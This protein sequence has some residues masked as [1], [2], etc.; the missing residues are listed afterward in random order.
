MNNQCNQLK[1]VAQEFIFTTNNN[2]NKLTLN[3]VL[4][5]GTYGKVYKGT[6]NG[7]LVAVKQINDVSII[8]QN[9]IKNEIDNLKKLSNKQSCHPN[10]LC[11]D[12]CAFYSEQ[13]YAYIITEYLNDYTDMDV[14]IKKTKKIDDKIKINLMKQLVSALQYIHS[15]NIV[16]GDIKPNN[17]M[18]S[19]DLSNVK[20]IDFGL[21]SI[22]TNDR[23]ISN[24]DQNN[25][26][27]CYGTLF[28]M[29]P[30]LL[31][32]TPSLT[33]LVNAEKIIRNPVDLFMSDIYSLGMTFFVL[34]NG[35]EKI[36]ES[37]E[38]IKNKNSLNNYYIWFM[39]QT[40]NPYI[41]QSGNKTID[42]V[43]NSMIKFDVDTDI[44]E[45][46]IKTDFD[47]QSQTL[48]KLIA[49]IGNIPLSASQSQR[50]NDNSIQLM[51]QFL[52]A[53]KNENDQ[54]RK[55]IEEQNKVQ[56]EKMEM[57]QSTEYQQKK[58]KKKE[59]MGKQSEL[60]EKYIKIVDDMSTNLI[61]RSKPTVQTQ[62]FPQA[63]EHERI[64]KELADIEIEL[65][66]LGDNRKT[67][68]QIQAIF[69]QQNGG[70]KKIYKFIN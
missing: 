10:I 48:D 66:K 51:Q 26:S 20:L 36:T 24:C 8:H 70:S 63:H 32:I 4:G 57:R 22:I 60:L 52:I 45:T 23:I 46:K 43:I 15:M 27:K 31:K 9:N 38:F 11:Y 67:L 49:D 30:E 56:Q 35:Y 54:K 19:N 65:L 7:A 21:S 42:D 25:R 47:D 34:A 59:L 68:T 6:L 62:L 1:L 28:Y 12:S 64:L 41:S 29:S 16:H 5:S 17:T 2:I 53:Q 50:S 14:I 55:H 61:E 33:Y 44:I 3:D 13:K 39:K 69:A 18:V 58:E 37:N 40:A